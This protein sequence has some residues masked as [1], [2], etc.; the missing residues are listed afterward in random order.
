MFQKRAFTVKAVW[1]EETRV[2]YSESDIEGLHIEA[3]TI[4]EFEKV[5]QDVAGELIVAN[6]ISSDELVHKPISELIP[7]VLWERPNIDAIPA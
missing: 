3:E 7:A 6:H 2:F 4:E 1:D 5:L